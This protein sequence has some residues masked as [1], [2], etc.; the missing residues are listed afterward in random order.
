MTLLN[1]FHLF[2]GYRKR[3]SL[4]RTASFEEVAA[5]EAEPKTEA[6]KENCKEQESRLKVKNGKHSNSIVNPFK[7]LTVWFF[8]VSNRRA[9]RSV[10][11]EHICGGSI[12]ATPPAD[13]EVEAP[14][15][16]VGLVFCVSKLFNFLPGPRKRS[17]PW[18]TS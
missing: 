14:F 15:T 2:V 1:N 7:S 5:K 3:P 17:G 6:E 8:I 11:E 4:R 16:D 13:P 10:S 9:A 18:K 12:C